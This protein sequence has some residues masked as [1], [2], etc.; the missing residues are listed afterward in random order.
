M[1]FQQL[2]YIIAVEEFKNFNRAALACDVAQ[3]TLSKEIQRLEKEHDVV[4]FDRT[5][6]PVV[7]TLKGIDLINKAKEILLLKKDFIQIAK[8]KQNEVSG[9]ITLAITEILAPY[10]APLFLNNLANKYP[11]LELKILE[12]SDRRIEDLLG[13]EEVDA[14]IMIAP[15]LSHDYFERKLFK[16]EIL[17][18]STEEIKRFSNSKVDINQLNFNSM[19]IHEDL[20][21]ILKRQIKEVFDKSPLNSKNNIKY[22]KGNLETI[23][24]IIFLNGGR[25]LIPKMAIPYLSSGSNTHFTYA[26]TSN[27]PKLDVS[28]I[29]TRGFEKNRIIKRLIT[30][31]LTTA[32][33]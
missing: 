8:K 12:L 14:A 7:P 11:N 24:N 30:E 27:T 33:V 20:K 5:R 32:S 29:S 16:E 18:Y 13:S 26:F 1:N 23:R 22:L 2:S 3:S 31:L 17:L 21:V 9:Y 19:F 10:I 28:L 4:I 25:M 6:N 15:D